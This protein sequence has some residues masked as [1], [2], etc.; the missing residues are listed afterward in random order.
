MKLR[1]IL[2]LLNEGNL[3]PD[4]TSKLSENEFHEI[5]VEYDVITNLRKLGHEVFP[6]EVGDEIV[7]VRKAVE[8]HK[9]HLAFNLLTHFRDVG[10]LDSYVVSYLELLGVPYTGCNPRGLILAS[11]KT[12]AKKILTYHRVR[13]PRFAHFRR[14][15]KVRPPKRLN[16]PLFVK[17]ASEHSSQ[18]IAQASI[19]KDDAELIER[20][21]FVHRTVNTDALAEEY[22]EG[23]ELNIAILGNQRLV[24]F[25]VWELLFNNLPKG[26]APIQ[27]SRLKWNVD[28][29]NKLGVSSE[30][31]EG[32]T[33]S[34]TAAIARTARRVYRAL[35]MSGYGRI[36]L[37]MDEGGQVWVLEA[38]PNPDLSYKEDLA[39]A[40]E[41][42]GL[43]Y[44]SLLQ[45]ICSLGLR[46]QPGWQAW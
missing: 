35:E 19:V 33:E 5:R 41:A 45:R 29:Q 44:P 39:N 26:T 14:N 15:L 8:E 22:I 18:G 3:P 37:R 20:V 21:E 4:D 16:Y 9:P 38:N 40:A 43:D 32:L 34:Q 13:V 28:Y 10:S 42:Y 12:L 11:D 25:P 27:T 23:R 7:P 17:S 24:S 30:R 2:V 1:R 6:L 31:A 36:D 46:Y